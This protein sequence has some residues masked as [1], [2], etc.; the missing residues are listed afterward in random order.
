MTPTIKLV[1]YEEFGRLRL[2][3]FCSKDDFYKESILKYSQG[4]FIEERTD[5]VAFWR[6]F[7][8]PDELAVIGIGSVG[9][10]STGW[11]KHIAPLVLPAIG[12]KLEDGLSFEEAA[13]RFGTPPR[14]RQKTGHGAIFHTGGDFPYEVNCGFMD[15]KTLD[16]VGIRRLDI[17]NLGEN[18]EKVWENDYNKLICAT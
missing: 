12:L 11:V 13:S 16:S 5:G 8:Q 2:R 7:K 17:Q 14:W 1:S 15:G 3:P 6:W 10:P 9:L 18:F 4:H